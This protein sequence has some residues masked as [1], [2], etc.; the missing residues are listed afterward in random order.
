[1]AEDNIALMAHL[2]RRAGFGA[3][4]DELESRVAKGYEA[5]VEELL[6][7]EEQESVDK[8]VCKSHESAYQIGQLSQAA[9]VA[10]ARPHKL[11]T[12]DFLQTIGKLL[13]QAPLQRPW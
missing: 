9:T 12:P 4:R 3:T 11:P 6:N 10:C 13:G 1:M 7:G 5:T 8:W 2:M